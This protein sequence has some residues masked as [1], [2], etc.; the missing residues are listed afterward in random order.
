[1]ILYNSCT[2]MVLTVSICFEY[3]SC[4]AARF[5]SSTTVS[6]VSW[7]VTSE[8]PSEEKTFAS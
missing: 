1:M 4:T 3:V 6:E 2:Q 7:N 8:S 5:G